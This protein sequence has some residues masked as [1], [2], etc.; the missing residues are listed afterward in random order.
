MTSSVH[1]DAPAIRAQDDAERVAGDA[2]TEGL[3]RC[4]VR[5]NA[6]RLH[7]DAAAFD[8]PTSGVRVTAP[9][10]YRSA[11]G[12][13]RFGTPRLPSGAAVSAVTLAALI[14]LEAT[15][16]RQHQQHVTDDL[17]GRVADSQAR[18]AQYLWHRAQHEDPVD[19]PPFLA[20]EQALVLG[21]PLHP[22][23]KSRQGIS[24][25]EGRRFSPELRGGFPLFWFAAD[26]SVV[27]REGAPV[28]ALAGFAPEVPPGTVP[29]PA[30][31]WQAREVLAKPEIR[32]LRERGLL[33]PLGEHG[34]EWYPTASVRTL[35]HPD[36]P[37][38]LKCSLSM[39][40]TNSVRENLRKELRRGAEIDRL[41]GGGLAEELAAQHP[42]FGI[43]RDPAW[44]AVD[45]P[46]AAESGLET[47][48]RDNPFRGGERACCVAGL[49]A[50]RP[51]RGPSRI[52]AVLERLAA[53]EG[54]GTAEIAE[55]WC[56]HYFDAVV[57]PVLWLYRAHGL[58]LEAHQ[59][60]T[61]VELDEQGWPRGG[62]YRDNQG[63]YISE[64][65]HDLHR[66]LPDIGDGENLCP[67]EL[68]NERL[69]Y[70]IGI[71]N[72]L[73]LVGA[74][75]NQGLADERR[76][77]AVL[78]ERLRGFDDLALARALAEEPTLRCKANLLTRIDGLDEL[79]GPIASQ[80]VYR[81]IPNP[82]V[83]ASS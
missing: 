75:G 78:R 67:D 51:D 69:G 52:A 77:L 27:S 12:H 44:I 55:R 11:T 13:H 40:I 62:W 63:Y 54:A 32:D 60:N 9:V 43:V 10:L 70:Y 31:P 57:A 61:L 71:N 56:A 34:P 42:G 50:E 33:E 48:V 45:V 58:G 30:H 73:G 4:W 22:A 5:E 14:G 41:L 19:A 76:L 79:V 24:P 80:S 2:T 26:P 35:Y 66:F 15:A 81:D 83:E 39:P 29:V 38:M 28:D 72:L 65:R 74:L 18:V 47:I 1:A 25:S 68:I 7:G 53:A 82:F 64:P 3:L 23:P 21:H 36:A 8:F 20:G 59:Q 16:G 46:A 17:V 6:L 37:V 49:V